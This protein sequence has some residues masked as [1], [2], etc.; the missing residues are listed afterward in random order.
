V[1][2]RITAIRAMVF[3][4]FTAVFYWFGGF[5]N[6]GFLTEDTLYDGSRLTRAW[7]YTLA[8]FFGGAFSVCFIEH[9]IG[10]LAPIN[11]RFRYVLGG[12]GLMAGGVIWGQMLHQA[13]AL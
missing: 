9:E 3:V 11:L 6:P 13:I 10:I 4:G 7:I 1:E 2:I 12:L 8:M 5:S